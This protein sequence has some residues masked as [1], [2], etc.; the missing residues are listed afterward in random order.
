MKP[1]SLDSKLFRHSFNFF[2]SGI[3]L[4]A[5][6]SE[7]NRFKD[8]SSKGAEVFLDYSRQLIDSKGFELLIELAKTK[9]IAEKFKSMAEGE[10]VNKTEKRPALHTLCRAEKSNHPLFKEIIRV[11][12]QIKEFSNK[13]H[14]GEIL[15]STGKKFENICVIGIGGSNLGTEFVVKALSYK[16]QNLN[17]FFIA[18]CDPCEI[19]SVKSSIDFEATLFVIIS[20]SYTTREVMINEDLINYELKQLNLNPKEHIV[21]VTSKNSPGDLSEFEVFHM[22]DSIGGRYSVSSAVGGLPISLVYG[23]DVFEEFLKGMNQ[24]DEHCLNS[25]LKDNLALISALIDI[26]NFVYLDFSVLG[27]IPYSFQLEKLPAHVQQLYMESNGKSLSE[28]NES[29]NHNTSMVIFGDTGTKSQHSFFQ[30]F[31]QGRTIPLEFIGVLSPPCKNFHKYENILNND[32]LFANLL[33]QADALAFGRNSD[34]PEKICKG[35]RPSS[36][37]TINDLSPL[38]IGKLVSFYEARTV[39]AGFLWEINPFDQFGVETGKIL[40]NEKRNTI[41]NALNNNIFPEKTQRDNYYMKA[42]SKR[43]NL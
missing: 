30:L 25:D 7:N 5:L 11:K 35:N 4:T 13:I 6:L 8:F 22:F 3:N 1:H 29:L 10:I 20:K 12:T 21:R 2:D 42:L 34:E 41:K 36:I 26:W 43:K 16:K 31:H 33:A 9:K 40:A 23:F 39:M 38:T 14:R 27:I 17:P 19:E 28:D 15:S 24:M 37:L 18:S 32:E